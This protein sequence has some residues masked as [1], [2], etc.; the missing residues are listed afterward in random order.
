MKIYITQNIWADR[1]DIHI[2]E[3]GYDNRRYVAKPMQL[4]FEEYK[5]GTEVPPSLSI[6]RIFGR[7]TNFLQSLSDALAKCGYE[8]KTV[9]E[10]RGE[11]KATKYH[12]EDM[13]TL[14]LK[15]EISK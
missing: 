7:S 6:S 3:E 9:E 4:E 11:L 14:V 5:E 10:N 12:L 2:F 15:K 13:R 8:P 1:Y